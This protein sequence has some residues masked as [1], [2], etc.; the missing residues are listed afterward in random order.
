[1]WRRHFRVVPEQRKTAQNGE[2]EDRPAY[3]R[4]ETASEAINAELK[5][6]L[7]GISQ[8]RGPIMKLKLRIS[9]I[10][11]LSAFVSAM[12]KK[13]TRQMQQQVLARCIKKRRAFSAAEEWD[14]RREEQNVG[15]SQSRVDLMKDRDEY[16]ED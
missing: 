11:K 1:M 2:P 16:R 8:I 5:L 7:R 4:R 13:T 10:A 3:R 9:Q 14:A 12:Y 15:W 6:W